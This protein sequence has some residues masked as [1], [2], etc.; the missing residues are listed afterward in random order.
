MD[1]TLR[2]A[3]A[4]LLIDLQNDFLA[5][6]G[7]LRVG[8]DQVEGL[9][10][11]VQDLVTAARTAGAPVA[12]IVNAFPRWSVGNLFRK[13]AAIEGSYGAQLDPRGPAPAAGE[14]TFEK[15][16]NDAFHRPALAHWLSDQGVRRVILAGVFA[17]ACVA[18]TARGAARHGFE[19]LVATDA[20]AA[21]SP[22]GRQSGIV[23]MNRRGATTLPTHD[24][25]HALREGTTTEGA[26]A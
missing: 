14:P 10:A 13:F 12:H 17:N 8:R 25:I 4:L 7:R 22:K 16:A 24:I 18:D 9:L 20:V 11:A 19:V 6:D 3:P 15:A 2:D 1:E 26:A 21:G 5:D 23:R